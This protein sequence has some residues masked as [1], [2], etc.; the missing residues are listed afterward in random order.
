VGHRAHGGEVDVADDLAGV[1]PVD[2]DVDHPRAR[3]DHV[4]ADD[5][6]PAGGDTDD[7]GPPKVSGEVPRP[8]VAHGDGGVAGEQ[9]LRERL[10]DQARAA[11]HDRFRADQRRPVVVED[12]H[13]ARRRARQHHGRAREEAAEVRGMQPVGVLGGGD[14]L[15]RLVL[16]EALGQRQ[17]EQDPVHG[18]VGVQAAQQVEQGRLLQPAGVEV[19]LRRDA[20]ALGRLLLVADVDLRRGVVPHQHDRQRGDHAGGAQPR[21]ALAHLGEDLLGDGPAV[22]DHRGPRVTREWTTAGSGTPARS[23]GRPR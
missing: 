22:E 9:Q 11:H 6:G 1:E 23:R 19:V 4:A 15:H 16:V 12:L 20:D 17:L 3:L 8:G 14:G 21:D 7:V 2:A 10:A 18:G 5:A 13:A